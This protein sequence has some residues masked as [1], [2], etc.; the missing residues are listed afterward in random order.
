MRSAVVSPS[1]GPL[2]FGSDE[3]DGPVEYVKPRPGHLGL[4]P[5]PS[6]IYKGWRT[7]RILCFL[8]VVNIACHFVL[9]LDLLKNNCL[10]S[11]GSV[12]ETEGVVTF[13]SSQTLRPWNVGVLATVFGDG[14]EHALTSLWYFGR[15]TFENATDVTTSAD[16]LDVDTTVARAGQRSWQLYTALFPPQSAGKV[17]LHVEKRV[18][19]LG[20]IF[21][22]KLPWDAYFQCLTPQP[23][24]VPLAWS[25]C[26]LV[27]THPL[28]R[29]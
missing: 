25:P 4:H 7:A 8:G 1:S 11:V 28:D 19:Y 3:G 27:R 16:G 18:R 23:G 26:V 5:G 14:D 29:S 6:E 17:T 20:E 21:L 9:L 2:R 13:Q 12:E 15:I 22:P 10:Y 24:F